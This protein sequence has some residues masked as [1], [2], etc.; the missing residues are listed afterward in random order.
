[1]PTPQ[2]WMKEQGATSIECYTATQVHAAMSLYHAHASAD[3]AEK[4]RRLETY[5]GLAKQMLIQIS[6]STER[7]PLL[8]EIEDLVEQLRSALGA[9]TPST[10]RGEKE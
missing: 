6:S 5:A 1:M 9:L 3:E 7:N 8:Q 2:E 10:E 4:V